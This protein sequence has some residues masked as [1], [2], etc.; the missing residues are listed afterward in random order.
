MCGARAVVLS[1]ENNELLKLTVQRLVDVACAKKPYDAYSSPKRHAA[2]HALTSMVHKRGLDRFFAS[3]EKTLFSQS[4]VQKMVF[5]NEETSG[6]LLRSLLFSPDAKTALNAAKIELVS[7]A[8][9]QLLLKDEDERA[10]HVAAAFYRAIEEEE[11][12]RYGCTIDDEEED[13]AYLLAGSSSSCHR[14]F[15]FQHL[16][17]DSDRSNTVFANQCV[18]NAVRHGNNEKNP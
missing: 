13:F 14:S 17:L 2:L 7:E 10:K 11:K 18:L 9:L 16:F 5:D 8:F 1:D 6:L 3:E 15:H 12:K 4:N